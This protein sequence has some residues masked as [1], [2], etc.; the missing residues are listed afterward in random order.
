MLLPDCS[1][2]TPSEGS[3][4]GLI[5]RAK[6]N[7]GGGVPMVAPG[8]GAAPVPAGPAKP[9]APPKTE[10]ELQW[11]QIEKKMARALK[12]GDMDFTDLTE[13]DE[14]SL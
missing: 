10:S 2:E 5:S 9:V 6:K 12:I 4:A 7:L 3:F 14:V 13:V 11:E 1:D 8:G